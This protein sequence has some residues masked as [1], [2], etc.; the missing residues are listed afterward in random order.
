MIIGKKQFDVKNNFYIMGILNVTPD[1]FSDGGRFYNID[2]ALLHVEK[3]IKSGADI[4]D[5]GGESTRPNHI[6]ISVEEEIERVMPVIT[7][8]KSN[9]DIPISLDSYKHEVAC[10]CVSHIDII[11][12]IWGFRYDNGEMAQLVANNGLACC[13]MHNRKKH[14]YTNFFDDFMSDMQNSISIA[15]K[16]GVSKDRIILDGGVGFQKNV[17]ENLIV[18][19]RTKELCSLGYPTMIATSRKSFIGNILDKNVADRL[20]GTLATT[21]WGIL[22][23]ASFI[24]VHDVDEN[25]DIIKIIRSIKEEQIWTK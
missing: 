7:A 22:Q 23:G 2:K 20:A 13:L 1:S 24:R 5:V 9:F 4:I 10:A 11:N 21:A 18:L 19:N 12:D 14:D 16:A 6:Q 8:I 3:M 15:L 25:N 17:E